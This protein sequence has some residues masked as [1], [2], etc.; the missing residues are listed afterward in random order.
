VS[1]PSTRQKNSGKTLGSKTGRG[2]NKHL[3][4]GEGKREH[5]GLEKKTDGGGAEGNKV[6]QTAIARIMSAT[7]FDEPRPRRLGRLTDNSKE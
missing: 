2:T 5:K 3:G 7:R 1:L 4:T 6:T